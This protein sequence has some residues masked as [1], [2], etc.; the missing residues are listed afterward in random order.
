MKILFLLFTLAVFARQALC[1]DGVRQFVKEYSNKINTISPDC[2]NDEDLKVI[3]QAIGSARVVMLGEQDHGDGPTYLAKGRLIKYLHDSLGFNVIAF[4]S[5]FFALNNNWPGVM[6]GNIKIK[7][8]FNGVYSVWTLCK[9]CNPVFQYI[10][11]KLTSKKPLTVTGFDSFLGDYSLHH[12]RGV[13]EPFLKSADIPFTDQPFYKE[14]FYGFTDSLLKL[15]TSRKLNKA[16]L[17]FVQKM[18]D[19]LTEILQQLKAKGY[20]N[21][22]Q[23]ITLESIQSE[24]RVLLYTNANQIVRSISERDHQMAV[25]LNWLMN[26]KYP[27]EKIIV[28]AANAH[29]M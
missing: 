25:N 26:V 12:Y 14:S 21:T 18:K 16:E 17:S 29:I 9:Q 8:Y 19:C 5:D 4:E 22:F 10:A 20:E 24:C 23:Y 11:D 15:N 13:V 1:Q 6:A 7:D 2:N 3:E 28:W 27:K